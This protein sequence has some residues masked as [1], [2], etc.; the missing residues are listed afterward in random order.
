MPRTKYAKSVKA[1]R[2]P[3]AALLTTI[4][5]AFTELDIRSN[6]KEAE[7]LGIGQTTWNGKIRYP[8]RI[9]VD[10][11]ILLVKKLNLTSEQLGKMFGARDTK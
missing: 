1:A 5:C 11:V 6:T 9:N 10:D 3:Y 8:N 4:H 7:Y 2:N